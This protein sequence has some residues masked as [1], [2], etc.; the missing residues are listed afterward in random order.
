MAT[1]FALKG[2]SKARRTAARTTA[3]NTA[4]SLNS[5]DVVPTTSLT[6]IGVPILI[7]DVWCSTRC[8][9]DPSQGHH[10]H[11]QSGWDSS[12]PSLHNA[13]TVANIGY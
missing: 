12:A 13:I 1:A 7:A 2:L 10:R 5:G 8:P 4:H 11:N 3:P 9:S 6:D